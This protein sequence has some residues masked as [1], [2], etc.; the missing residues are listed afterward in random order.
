MK[1]KTTLLIFIFAV[2]FIG[3]YSCKKEAFNI[4]QNP[5]NATDSTIT[6]EVILPSAQNATARLVSR[7]WGWL[8]NYLGYWARSGTYAPNTQEET[9]DITT[10][11]QSQIWSGFY[12]NLYDYEVMQLAAAKE[13]AT[14]Y[15]GIAKIMKAH[16]YEILVSIYDNVPY[17]E[18]LQIANIKTPK[19][20]K[21]VD[22]YKDLLFQIDKGIDLIKKADTA[23]AGPNGNVISNDVMFGDLVVS[24]TTYKQMKTNWAKFANTIKLRILTKFMNGGVEGGS[25]QVGTAAQY[26]TGVDLAVEF[27]KIR[28]EGS[29]FLDEVTGD[30]VVNPGYATDKGNPFYNLYIKDNNGSKTSSNDYYKGNYFAVG[31]GTTDGFYVQL[32]DDRAYGFYSQVSGKLKGVK[33]GLASSTDNSADKLSG[34]GFGLSYAADES[35]RIIT[36]AE[37][38][39]LQAECIHRGFISGD[40]K[41]TLNEGIAASFNT[42]FER[43]G[44]DGVTMADTYI[45]DNFDVPAVDY[46]AVPVDARS[47]AG[48]IYTII[49]QKWLALNGIAPYEVWSDYRRI[50]F[51]STTHHFVY[52]G[53]ATGLSQAFIAPPI[54]VSTSKPASIKEIPLRLLYPQSEYLYNAANVGAQPSTGTYPFTRTFWD[55]N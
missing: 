53:R 44:F 7:N 1:L 5:N 16:D 17:K 33:Y 15:E 28:N 38:K 19:Y 11:F 54:S 27:N 12:D 43:F 6:Y 52:G 3:L 50:D 13:G 21:G 41:T 2:L 30:A 32:L 23:E 49:T 18:A 26:A 29:G 8:Q 4:N 34:I 35:Q 14:F 9:Y 46:S 45:A 55:L 31:D 20:D 22:I 10:N 48:G 39:M 51:S 24:G 42:L 40:A 25:A 36:V 37:S 47:A